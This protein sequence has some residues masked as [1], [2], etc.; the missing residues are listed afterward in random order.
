LGRVGR[1]N[2][3]RQATGVCVEEYVERSRRSSWSRIAV[4]IHALDVDT[5]DSPGLASRHD[6]IISRLVVE[7]GIRSLKVLRIY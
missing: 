4:E 1:S 2:R 7:G 3:S 6:K 5:L